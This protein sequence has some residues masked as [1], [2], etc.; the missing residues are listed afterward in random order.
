MT[1]SNSAEVLARQ[2]VEFEA[3]CSANDSKDL[4]AFATA[5]RLAPDVIEELERCRRMEKEL[6]SLIGCAEFE[7]NLGKVARPASRMIGNYRLLK[8]L[9][10][11]GMGTVWLAQQSEPM[12]RKVAI[13]LIRPDRDSSVTE[14]RFEREKQALALMSHA[15]VA[16]VYEAG[17]AT[18]GRQYIAMEYVDGESITDYCKDRQATLATRLELFLQLCSAIQHAHQAGLLHRDIK[19][20]NILVTEVDG[21]P[22]VK[23]IDFGLVRPNESWDFQITEADMIVGSPLW[24]SPEQAGGFHNAASKNS[25]AKTVDARTDVY[26][27]GVILYQLLTDTT[28]IVEEFYKHATKFDLLKTIH[29]EVPE[30]PSVRVGKSGFSIGNNSNT[31]SSWGSVLRKELDWITMRALEKECD[32]RYPAVLDFAEDIKSYLQNDPVTARPPSITYRLTKL[33]QK[34]QTATLS[35]MVICVLIALASSGIW[36]YSKEASKQ[37]ELARKAEQH[38][39]TAEQRDGRKMH[40]IALMLKKY[41][42][43][44][45]GEVFEE[46]HLRMLDEY[47]KLADNDDYSGDPLGEAEYRL[48]LADAY[49]GSA[50]YASA[51]TQ[52]EK[53]VQLYRD[54]SDSNPRQQ[55][56]AN[57]RLA[58]EHSL[59]WA[60]DKALPI[61]EACFDQ[62]VRLFGHNDELTIAARTQ[63]NRSKFPFGNIDKI[64][65]DLEK[66]AEL[67]KSA[68]G[69]T[70]HVTI[71]TIAA[72]G[73]A[74]RV[75]QNQVEAKRQIKAALKL[76][77]QHFGPNDRRTMKLRI[78]NLE[79]GGCTGCSNPGSRKEVDELLDEYKQK[80][81][82]DHLFTVRLRK[83]KA[84]LA[85][86]DGDFASA[87]TQLEEL[88][89][90]CSEKFGKTHAATI[91]SRDLLGFAYLRKSNYAE[92][93][94]R[95]KCLERSQEIFTEITEDFEKM[96]LSN[97]NFAFQAW[98]FRADTILATRRKSDL[99]KALSIAEHFLPKSER[100]L[101]LA[102]LTTAHFRE[103]RNRCLIRLNRVKE[104]AKLAANWYRKSEVVFDQPSFFT[105][106]ASH[107]IAELC[108]ALERREEAREYFERNHELL[109]KL[110]SESAYLTLRSLA[111]LYNEQ[112]SLR[113][114]KAAEANA[115]KLIEHMPDKMGLRSIFL[116]DAEVTI[117]E[118]LYEQGRFE[119]GR[120]IMEKVLESPGLQANKQVDVAAFRAANE[121]R[122]KLFEIR[123]QSSLA[124]SYTHLRAHETDS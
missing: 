36:W 40:R 7:A 110:H 29:N 80:F 50:E 62:S 69:E 16:Q 3:W 11:G 74:Y 71:K 99:E 104:A 97:S 88:I 76:S 89:E 32:R 66:T 102:S 49:S 43:S 22:T 12:K 63:T 55:I 48:M 37:A 56:A 113:D 101:G 100:L 116:L 123:A 35:I 92:D 81:G 117:G 30:L 67:A 111:F 107:S 2:I 87:I 60:D 119:E 73:M 34:H 94:G 78:Q 70:H 17:T 8:M 44:S 65:N 45:D 23:V 25:N 6:S 33:A 57:L 103:T 72:L 115:R 24:M 79:I 122:L 14:K 19:P 82:P 112:A 4:N 42:P 31:V 20:D 41:N 75:T 91:E 59:H 114:Y 124:V 38:R 77:Q 58:E 39:D 18:D 27:L 84:V 121:K 46:A 54:A 1:N 53:V 21:K 9:G 90:V 118:S 93:S 51:I 15:H 52:Y 47:R 106:S 68:L 120:R 13:K 61:A 86:S 28:P 85:I 95:G 109:V 5:R 83:G 96:N 64:V 108:V 105:A 98:A 10:V 26:S